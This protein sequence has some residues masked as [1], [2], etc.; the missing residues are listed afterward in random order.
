MSDSYLIEQAK[1][2]IDVYISFN[3]TATWRKSVQWT[4]LKPTSNNDAELPRHLMNTGSLWSYGP[5][6]STK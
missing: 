5:R 6:K 1:Q 3:I 4:S 2:D